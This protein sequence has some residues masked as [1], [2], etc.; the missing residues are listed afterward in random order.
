MPK[1]PFI[2]IPPPAPLPD[3]EELDL[4]ALRSAC[5]SGEI[6][7]IC[8]LG[9]TASGKTHFAVALADALAC[10]SAHSS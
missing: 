6:D 1:R 8:V 4:D 2:P 5:L 7:L 9:P 3:P 10:H